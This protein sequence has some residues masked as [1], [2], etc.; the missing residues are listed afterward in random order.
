MSLKNETVG[1]EAKD[2]GGA[3]LGGTLL[4]GGLATSGL[5]AASGLVESGLAYIA[6]A[7]FEMGGSAVVIGEALG[8]A[9]GVIGLETER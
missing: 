5:S 6:G 3:A 9:A 1:T 8:T 4:G 2:L 7:A